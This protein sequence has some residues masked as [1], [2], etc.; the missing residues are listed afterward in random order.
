MMHRAIEIVVKRRF[1]RH[2]DIE[3]RPRLEVRAGDRFMPG[4]G[5]HN[6]VTQTER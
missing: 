6:G 1:I 4:V 3:K 2:T 5:I